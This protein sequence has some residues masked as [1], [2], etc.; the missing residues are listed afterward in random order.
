[1]S[2]EVVSGSKEGLLFGY[3]HFE[4]NIGMVDGM[5]TLDRA[6]WTVSVRVYQKIL[7]HRLGKKPQQES[8]QLDVRV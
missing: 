2:I 5:A 7:V 4:S 6:Y 1:M 3:N 8:V